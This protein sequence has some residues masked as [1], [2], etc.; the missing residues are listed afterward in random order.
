MLVSV[1][2]DRD[3]AKLWQESMPML[4]EDVMPTLAQHAASLHA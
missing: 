2:R 1:G 3:D 4:A